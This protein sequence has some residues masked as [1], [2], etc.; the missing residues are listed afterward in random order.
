MTRTGS[1]RGV[2]GCGE[3][4]GER[5]WGGVRL[6]GCN[7]MLISCACPQSPCIIPVSFLL[8]ATV[9]HM[10]LHTHSTHSTHFTELV[11]G[12]AARRAM[13][14]EDVQSAIAAAPLSATQA[15]QRGLVNELCYF[16]QVLDRITRRAGPLQPAS[17]TQDAAVQGVGEGAAQEGGLPTVDMARYLRSVRREKRLETSSPVAS[18]KGRLHRVFCLSAC[19]WSFSM[20][21]VFFICCVCFTTNI[22]H[23]VSSQRRCSAWHQQPISH[24]P[25]HHPRHPPSLQS[26]PPAARSPLA[27]APRTP[28]ASPSK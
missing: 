12:V 9:V 20:C 1:G 5:G 16:D 14:P 8:H 25:L 22:H 26:S 18:L 15:L 23:S 11:N 17:T 27:A 28:S 19:V 10:D 21:F 7:T 3:G 13:A 2:R 24:P 6:G 4:C